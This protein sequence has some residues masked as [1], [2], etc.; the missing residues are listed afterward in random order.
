MIIPIKS[1]KSILPIG[2]QEYNLNISKKRIL[3]ENFFGRLKVVWG[4]W[5]NGYNGHFDHLD[6][7]FLCSVG[8][9]NIHLKF[10]PLRKNTK[11]ILV[12]E[13]SEELDILN[14]E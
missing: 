3:I 2:N 6:E 5:L 12:G 1:G 7:R 11:E 10:K 9:T 8:L 13:D 4:I 14:L